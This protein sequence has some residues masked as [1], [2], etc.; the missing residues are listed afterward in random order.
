MA[1]DILPIVILKIV[2]VNISSIGADDIW[3]D[4]HLEKRLHLMDVNPKI[5]VL[6]GSVFKIDATSKTKHAIEYQNHLNQFDVLVKMPCNLWGAIIRSDFFDKTG[7]YFNPSNYYNQDY[8]WM[9][10]CFFEKHGYPFK[11]HNLKEI[12]AKLA[13]NRP[14]SI[15]VASRQQ[16]AKQSDPDNPYL[17]GTLPYYMVVCD[18]IIRKLGIKPYYQDLMI[19]LCLRSEGVLY[20]KYLNKD[21]DDVV[22]WYEKINLAYKKSNYPDYMMLNQ[23]IFSRFQ[24][25]AH[26]LGHDSFTWNGHDVKLKKHPKRYK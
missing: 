15:S 13:I 23:Y 19:H 20:L 6:A 4:G 10:K 26:H 2:R 24:I 17:K 9:A 3:A 7:I 8:E 16:H 11:L 18:Y 5:T 12:V 1:S 14:R 22:K 25:I 21:I